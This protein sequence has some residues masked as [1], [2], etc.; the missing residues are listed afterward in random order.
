MFCCIFGPF[1]LKAPGKWPM[2]I[3]VWSFQFT[4]QIQFLFRLT[5]LKSKFFSVYHFLTTHHYQKAV[6]LKLYDK[7]K[8]SFGVPASGEDFTPFK[9]LKNLTLHKLKVSRTWLTAVSGENFKQSI[10][11]KNL[12][13]SCLRWKCFKNLTCIS[14][15]RN[16]YTM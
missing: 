1:C 3:F 14:I 13:Y 4:F 12:S 9:D 6:W 16:F 8:Y 7:L 2:K 10:V 11:L 15:M 5:L